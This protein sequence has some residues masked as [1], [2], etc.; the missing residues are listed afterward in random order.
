MNLSWLEDFLALAATGNFS[1][2]AEERHMTQPAFS[3]RVRALEE[4][5]GTELF[6]RSVQPA[7]LTVAGEWFRPQAEDLLARVARLPPEARAMAQAN[8]STL[9]L[10]ATHALSFTFVPH[11]LQA[12]QAHTSRGPI[13]LVSDVLQHCEA[14][15]AKHEV[16]FVIAHAPAR[17]RGGFDAA[18]A[19]SVP[20]GADLLL[21]VH[22]RGAPE[23]ALLGFSDESGLG[24]IV[25]QTLGAELAA[26][27]LQPVFTAHL[28]SVLKSM[29]LEGRG[30]AWLPESMVRDELAAARLQVAG[31]AHWRIPVEIRLYRDPAPLGAH[32]EAFWQAASGGAA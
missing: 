32:A 2:A 13:R 3:R 20:I 15:L 18:G 29:A 6:D 14:L 24:R 28:A 30:L 4:W 22:G 8:A 17:S 12:L 1:R 19:P 9:R 11:W 10:A 23:R 16:Q 21:P 31:P 27:G 25:R 26:A 5:L 7:R